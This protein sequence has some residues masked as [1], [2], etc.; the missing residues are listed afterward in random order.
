MKCNPAVTPQLSRFDM[1]RSLMQ[2][3]YRRMKFTRRAGTTSCPPVPKG[4]YEECRSENL[5][6]VKNI[7]AE[8]VL[9]AYKHKFL[10]FQW[11]G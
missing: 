11:E 9:Y 8:M 2:S 1:P 10:T 7:L 6:D 3:L 4:I 5:R